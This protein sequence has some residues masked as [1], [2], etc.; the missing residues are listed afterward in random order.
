MSYAT[1]DEV[2]KRFGWSESTL[3]RREREGAVKPYRIGNSRPYYNVAE[4]EAK[5]EPVA[6]A[7]EKNG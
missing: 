3:I 1:R 4:I 5:F 6:K 2:L 7:Q